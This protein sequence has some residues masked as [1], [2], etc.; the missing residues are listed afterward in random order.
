MFVRC[1][2]VFKWAKQI[3]KRIACSV[4][5]ALCESDGQHTRYEVLVFSALMVTGM[6]SC[7]S[8]YLITIHSGT[9]PSFHQWFLKV[10]FLWPIAFILTNTV[11]KRA[12]KTLI[13]HV[14]PHVHNAFIKEKLFSILKVS[15][16]VCMMSAIGVFTSGAGILSFPSFWISSVLVSIIIALPLNLFVVGPCARRIYRRVFDRAF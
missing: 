13:P 14:E 8:L 3:Y 10:V 12:V 5:R 9:L 11:A 7:M 6:I 1:T 15:M 2:E 4:R 16:M